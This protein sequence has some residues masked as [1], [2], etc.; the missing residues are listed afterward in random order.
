MKEKKTFQN[1]ILLT[2][3]IDI[4]QH[5][6]HFANF[7]D[8]DFDVFEL[9]DKIGRENTLPLVSAFLYNDFKMFEVIP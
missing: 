6:S 3:F 4:S 5:E 9:K 1:E 8:K 7:Y 2:S